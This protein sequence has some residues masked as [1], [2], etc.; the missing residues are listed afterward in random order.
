MN[1]FYKN[2]KAAQLSGFL[3][4]ADRTGLEPAT[5]RVTGGYSNQL[6]YRS[7]NFDWWAVQ[8]SNL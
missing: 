2:K 6:N 3:N 8:D 7:K 1:D 5:T 4:M